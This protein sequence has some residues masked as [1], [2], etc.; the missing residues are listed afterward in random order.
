[1]LLLRKEKWKSDMKS[2][3]GVCGPKQS[4]AKQSRGKEKD[5]ELPSVRGVGNLTGA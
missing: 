4:K 1:M 3:Q 2:V 5:K